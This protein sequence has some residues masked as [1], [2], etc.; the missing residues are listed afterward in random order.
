MHTIT[1]TNLNDSGAGSLSEAIEFANAYTGT[2]E[3]QI[4]IDESLAGQTI[5][6]SSAL[7]SINKACSL[8][9]PAA[10][11]ILTGGLTVYANLH[12]ENI[13]LPSMVI[14]HAVSGREVVFTGSGRV[15]ELTNVDVSLANLRAT[16]TP[17]NSRL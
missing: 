7:P 16:A 6:L 5:M 14:N 10:G 2:D 1:V 15:I 11:I 13:I 4:L 12:M 9:A 17:T 8:M 3:I